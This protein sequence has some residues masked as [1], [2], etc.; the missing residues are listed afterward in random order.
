MPLVAVSSRAQPRYVW[1]SMGS[2]RTM[3]SEAERLDG[4]MRRYACGEDGIFEELYGLMAPRLF[5]FC[6]RLALRRQESED[7]FQETMLRVHRARATYRPGANVM[8]WAFAI[9]RAAHLDRLRYRRRRPE[10]LG[11]QKDVAGQDRLRSD[12]Q[13]SP[14]A[15][16]RARDLHALVALELA[17]M[18][19]KN[20][21]AYVLLK[22]EGLSARE[23]A[24][25][26]GTSTA[27]VKQRAHRAYEHLRAALGAAGWKED[28]DDRSWSELALRTS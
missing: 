13:H 2:D 5:R 4:L 27:V 21:A 1:Q 3:E 18:S 17:R 14:E 28:G 19:E 7:L 26:L 25:V 8:Y 12:E 22:E 10:D 24:A 20:R 23:A 9:S 16:V 15:A 11:S 6:S